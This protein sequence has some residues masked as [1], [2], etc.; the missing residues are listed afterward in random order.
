METPQTLADR[1]AAQQ[2]KQM[3]L[4]E[5]ESTNLKDHIDYWNS[6]RQENVLGYYARKEG[7]TKLGLQPLPVLGILEYKAK[8]A[9]KM[10][11]LLTSLSK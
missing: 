9:I 7:L 6:V 11:L 4:I 10:T 1:F 3:T 5:N 8:E 2:E